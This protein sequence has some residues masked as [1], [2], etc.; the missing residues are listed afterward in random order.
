LVLKFHADQNA[1]ND[2]SKKIHKL[3]TIILSSPFFGFDSSFELTYLGVSSL[4]TV[5]SLIS[6]QKQMNLIDRFPIV[7]KF[8]S[9]EVKN[10]REAVLNAIGLQGELNGESNLKYASE[11]LKNDRDVV[12]EAVRRDSRALSFA[13]QALKNDRD[14]ILVAVRQNACALQ[15][16]SDALKN[17]RELVLEAVRQNGYALQYASND[18]KN[19]SLVVFH[20]VMQNG[21]AL[22]YASQALKN[23]REIVLA[24]VRLD[25]AVLRFAS[26]D[27]INDREF[28]LVN[29]REFVL[30]AQM[31]NGISNDREVVLA[32]VRQKGMDLQYASN[33][34]K[35]DRE[36]VLAAVMQNGNALYFVSQDLKNDRELVFAAVTTYPSA[37]YYASDD[38]KNDKELALSAVRQ[39]G[40]ALEFA[41]Q[42]LK[43]DREIVLAAV[44]QNGLTFR[45]ASAELKNDREFVLEAVRQNGEAL[46]YASQALKNDR[47]IVLAAVSQ[48]GM[49]LQY[50]SLDLK[51]DRDVVLAAVR[52][53]GE[54]LQ[55]AS[56]DIKS[57]PEF[58]MLIL[59]L[60]IPRDRSL[61]EGKLYYPASLNAELKEI[62]LPPLPE[63]A[64]IEHLRVHLSEFIEGLSEEALPTIRRELGFREFS[65][66]QCKA[67]LNEYRNFLFTRVDGKVAYLGTPPE[68][69]PEL[70][71]FYQKLEFYLKHLD[72]FFSKEENQMP[73]ALIE[74]L[75]L[76]QTQSACGARFQAETEQLFST[77]CIPLESMGLANQFALISSSEAKKIIQS[78]VPDSNVHEINILNWQLDTYLVGSRVTRDTLAHPRDEATLMLEFLQKHTSVNLVTQLQKYLK[79]RSPLGQL[80]EQYVEENLPYEITD[81][82][83]EEQVIEQ[84]Q[85]FIGTKVNNFKK[86]QEAKSGNG[87]YERFKDNNEQLLLIFKLTVEESQCLNEE[88]LISLLEENRAQ[89]I[90]TITLSTQKSLKA[91]KIY[92]RYFDSEKNQ[93][94][95]STIALVL[96]RMQILSS[97]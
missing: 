14:F 80:F 62:R 15:Y 22:F 50:A 74:R 89:T 97:L 76:L 27:L 82:E 84:Y 85:G 68:G 1:I 86:Y 39:D 58:L 96:E 33:D 67:K 61:I 94:K 56:N 72:F 37:F 93:W 47:E 43:N 95:D 60:F 57:D 63:E 87:P 20:A 36:V 25:G 69:T 19:D 70:E 16:A 34:L 91:E 42:A 83:I 65:L 51:N 2:C 55:Y 4:E 23:D 30:A 38:L 49:A 26:A 31:Q 66:Q 12:L 28:V 6:H 78:M 90:Q 81:P 88:A 29:D 48:D 54:A 32:A 9:D 44:R 64:S 41:S 10:N 13:S 7:F 53:N 40:R 73:K 77:N 59:P 71:E 24:A 45:I 8:L 5:G 75:Q 11:D 79:E 46:Q 92:E 17:D 52:Q 21:E 3:A 35:N 18:L